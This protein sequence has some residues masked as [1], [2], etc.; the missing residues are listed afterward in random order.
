MRRE[1][2]PILTYPLGGEATMHVVFTLGI[3][4]SQGQGCG[5]KPLNK[6]LSPL[7]T[8]LGAL[9]ITCAKAVTTRG[10]T[11]ELVGNAF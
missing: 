6:G 2:V 8:F 4:P 11:H 3:V 7:P 10:I 5:F 1:G 9:H